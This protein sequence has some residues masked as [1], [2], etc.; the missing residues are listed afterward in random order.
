MAKEFNDETQIRLRRN[1]DALAISGSMVIALS[2]WDIIKLYIGLFLGEETIA[3]LIGTVMEQ[4]GS[5][6][7]GTEYEKT[8]SVCL[9]VMI[10]LMIQ[11][12]SVAVFLYHLY[13]GLNAFRAGRQTAGKQSNFYIVLTVFSTVFSGILL[14]L[15]IM[16]LSKPSDP[17]QNVDVAFF[18]MEVTTLI[19]YIYILTAV[20]MIRKLEKAEKR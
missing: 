17:N 6:V 7:I 5:A 14:I 13:I 19:N 8:V 3:Q 9:W 12:F 1:R 4:S 10:L 16:S 11:L 2:I 20:R 18:V 15:N